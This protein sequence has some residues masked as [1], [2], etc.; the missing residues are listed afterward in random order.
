MNFGSS[1]LRHASTG[2]K[3]TKILCWETD[4]NSPQTSVSLISISKGMTVQI[5]S[6]K[7]LSRYL[8]LNAGNYF[9]LRV[10]CVV[11]SLGCKY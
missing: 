8:S 5:S 7:D 1:S 10:F 11:S 6:K 2:N 3:Q 9:Q 4:S